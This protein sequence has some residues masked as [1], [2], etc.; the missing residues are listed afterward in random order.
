MRN[1]APPTRLEQ[2]APESL[3]CR[4]CRTYGKCGGMFAPTGGFR[5]TDLCDSLGCR[6]DC[7]LVSPAHA[8]RY[9]RAVAEVGGFGVD[10]LEA[11][12]PPTALPRHVSVI[13]HGSF[14]RDEPVDL[15][16]VGVPLREVINFL[17]RPREHALPWSERYSDGHALR[18]DFGVPRHAKVM[19]SCIDIDQNIEP[20]WEHLFTPGFLNYFRRL[21]LDAVVVPNFSWWDHEPRHHHRYNRKRSLIVAE[22]FTRFGIPVV[23]YF[24]A[25]YPADVPFWRDFLQA[26]PRI[27]CIAEEF[28]TGLN[29]PAR[30]HAILDT[31]SGL[32][33]DLGRPL[34]LV[35]IGGMR[36]RQAIAQRFAS[37]TIVS[38]KAFLAAANRRRLVRDGTRFTEVDDDSPPRQ[39]FL[40]NL[41]VVEGACH[42]ALIESGA[43]TPPKEGARILPGAQFPPSNP[44][45]RCPSSSTMGSLR[46]DLTA[47]IRGRGRTA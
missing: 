16:W 7:S 44:P 46:S 20:V 13:Q 14:F 40:E 12:Q 2:L 18:D 5:C 39:T 23:P 22:E 25:L 24:H 38:S 8:E 45:E 35:A 28:Q 26:H 34:H 3:G 17:K 30:A 6:P 9:H 21:G 33:S 42:T 31:L 1:A 32:Q 11:I 10:D 37:S 29:D 4:T 47:S 43:Y 41:R 15:P 36:H 27:T 19:L